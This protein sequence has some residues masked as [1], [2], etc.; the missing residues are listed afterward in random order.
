MNILEGSKNF[1]VV[2]ES[3][4]FT[5]KYIFIYIYNIY[6]IFYLNVI[7]YSCNSQKIHV[8]KTSQSTKL[9]LFFN[10]P[11]YLPLSFLFLLLRLLFY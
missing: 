2:C 7:Y 3:F 5:F 8:K 10:F 9:S 6:L 11:F 4:F 1:C